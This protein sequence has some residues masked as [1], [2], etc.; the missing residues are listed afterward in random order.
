MYSGP[1]STGELRLL[2]EGHMGAPNGNGSVAP[3]RS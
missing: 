1:G 3:A 2:V